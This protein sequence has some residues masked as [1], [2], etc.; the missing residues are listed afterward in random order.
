MHK[1]EEMVP[2]LSPREQ[3]VWRLLAQGKTNQ[4]IALHLGVTLGTV[5]AYIYRLYR[6]LRVSGRVEA[7]LRW[8]TTNPATQSSDSRSLL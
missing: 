7:A 6:K 2:R 8:T 3:E 1:R 5:K 4:E